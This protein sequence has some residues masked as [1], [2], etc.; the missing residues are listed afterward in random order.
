VGVYHDHAG[1]IAMAERHGLVPIYAMVSNDD[2]WDDFE[3][4]H[5]QCFELA[6]RHNPEDPEVRK[7]LRSSR[8]WRDGYL[9]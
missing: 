5:R 9:G 4:G 6:A 7:R 1:N 8:E 3:W 2:E